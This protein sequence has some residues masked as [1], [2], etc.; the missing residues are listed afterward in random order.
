MKSFLKEKKL[1]IKALLLIDNAPSHPNEAELT[2]E[3]GKICAMFMPP[4][5]TPLIQPMDQNA[6]KITKLHYRNSLL[7]SI[8]ATQSD[9]LQSMKKITLDKAINLLDAAWSRVGEETL[10]RCWNNILSF[11]K[12]DDDPED[13]MPLA[14]LKEKWGAELRSLMCNTVDLLHSLSAE[15]CSCTQTCTNIYELLKI[16]S[17]LTISE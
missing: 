3:D 7:A 9:L 13:S 11:P 4:N 1:P 16:L 14:V 8:A 2:T 17:L 6:I 15:V 12:S 10:A 5:V